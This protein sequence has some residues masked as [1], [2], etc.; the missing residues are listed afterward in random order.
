[1][2]D[3]PGDDNTEDVDGQQAVR[4]V[5]GDA[6][7]KLEK[8]E[9]EKGE[10]SG[11]RT[12][13]NLPNGQVIGKCDQDVLLE[14]D[15]EVICLSDEEATVEQNEDDVKDS[16][17]SN[18]DT[19]E[20]EGGENEIVVEREI[21]LDPSGQVIVSEGGE[22]LVCAEKDSLNNN[23][24]ANAVIERPLKDSIEESMGTRSTK[25]RSRS[26]TFRSRS[27]SRSDVSNSW[28]KRSRQRSRSRS[29]RHSGNQFE[30]FSPNKSDDQFDFVVVD[31]TSD[32]DGGGDAQDNGDSDDVEVIKSNLAFAERDRRNRRTRSRSR[33]R[34][35]RSRSRSSRRRL[36][37]SRERSKSH[38]RD[39]RQK[40]ERRQRGR[41]EDS[42]HGRRDDERRRDR[43]WKDKSGAFLAR[44]GV[45]VDE[46]SGPSSYLDS[47][48][49]P[50]LQQLANLNQPPP[51]HH[52]IFNRRH[53][54]PV[55]N[56]VPGTS[57]SEPGGSTEQRWNPFPAA[58]PSSCVGQ[59]LD[60]RHSEVLRPGICLGKY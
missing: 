14:D 45:S 27:R 38:N 9:E 25:E 44:L 6:R 35:S 22:K 48:N 34:R 2:A 23:F 8:V 21:R 11:T 60:F 16:C 13:K 33:S 31:C 56:P 20:E 18:G 40:D 3:K 32:D 29:R 54:P 26:R 57:F 46:R 28:K 15:E 7:E 53:Q 41:W 58:R 30:E 42:R 50:S 43:E 1:M 36:S 24:D 17:Q 37:L 51:P 47:L 52:P 49:L 19:M 59:D 4:K 5:V 12:N 39:W 55:C 10:E